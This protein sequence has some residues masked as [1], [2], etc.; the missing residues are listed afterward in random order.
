MFRPSFA[1]FFILKFVRNLGMKQGLSFLEMRRKF[2]FLY[3][4]EQLSLSYSAVQLQQQQQDWFNSSLQPKNSTQV[5]TGKFVFTDINVLGSVIPNELFQLRKYL[6][7]NH[8]T[9]GYAVFFFFF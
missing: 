7:L 5:E 6:K 9:F 8:L 2:H 4:P 3:W 1:H